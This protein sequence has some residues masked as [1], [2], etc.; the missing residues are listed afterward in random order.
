MKLFPN[1]DLCENKLATSNEHNAALQYN[2]R[3]RCLIKYQSSFIYIVKQGTISFSIFSNSN[4][5]H[6]SYYGVLVLRDFFLS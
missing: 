2:F 1:L 3:G 4:L 5:K 6:L